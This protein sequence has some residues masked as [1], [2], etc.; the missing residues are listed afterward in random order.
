MSQRTRART[1]WAAVLTASVMVAACG[2]NGEGLDQDGNPVTTPNPVPVP[3]P[4]DPSV[5]TPDFASIQRNVFTPICSTCHGA[6]VANAGM[7][8]NEGNAYA[9]IVNVNSAEMPALKRIK[10]ND[11]ANSYLIQKL[12]GAST[13][14]GD[15]MPLGGPYLS[16][17]QI[18]VIAQWV[19]LGAPM[20]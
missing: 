10:P 13:I 14:A 12:R 6:A 3:A 15:R 11:S 17:Q 16:T 9:N 7:R 4:T 5:L 1:A 8:L 2:G 18:D 20:N 19:D